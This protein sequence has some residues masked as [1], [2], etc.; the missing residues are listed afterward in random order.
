MRGIN[1]SSTFREGIGKR[2]TSRPP[3]NCIAARRAWDRFAEAGP[4]E[5]VQLLDGYWGCTRPG[6]DDLEE[7]E[8]VHYRREWWL[9]Y[10]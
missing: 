1:F 9:K 8:A 4:I 6:S 2:Y 10:A 7:V 3:A 5:W